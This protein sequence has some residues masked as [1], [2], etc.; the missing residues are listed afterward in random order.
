MKKFSKIYLPLLC[1]A[2]LL[3]AILGLSSCGSD[4]KHDWEIGTTVS[5][6]CNH[7]G[8]VAYTCKKCGDIKT[9]LT[10]ET[11]HSFTNYVDDE[12]ATCE[13]EGTK[14][15]VCDNGCGATDTQSVPK[16]HVYE[17]AWTATADGH[18]HVC[19]VCGGNDGL[20]AHTPDASG[21]ACTVCNYMIHVHNPVKMPTVP[22]T[23]TTAG[24]IE[25]W[26]CGVC[27]KNFSDAECTN[28][29]ANVSIA[30][31][32]HTPTYIEAKAAT[33]TAPGNL[34]S[35][36]CGTC[37]KHYSDEA[38][39][40]PLSD[41]D[42]ILPVINHI[43]NANKWFADKNGHWNECA[44][45]AVDESSRANHVPG[46]AAT[47]YTDQLCTVCNYIITPALNHTHS[48][49]HVPAKDASCTENGNVEYWACACGKYFAD[50]SC[51]VVLLDGDR[52]IAKL[53]H[54][55]QHK[56]A[57][58]P[59]CLEDGYQEHWYCERCEKHFSDK[60]L[61]Y[62]ISYDSIVRRAKHT[63]VKWIQ[64]VAATCTKDG[65]ITYWH[66]ETCNK[67]YSDEALK[68]EITLAD[69]VITATGHNATYVN[70]KA[71]TCTEKGTLGYWTCNNCKKNYTTV[72]CTTIFDIADRT[73]DA[74]GHD[75][76]EMPVSTVPPTCTEGGYSVFKCIRENCG[77]SVRDAETPPTGHNADN[78]VIFD[79]YEGSCQEN[80]YIIYTCKDNCGYERTEYT[81][82]T[83]HDY[84]TATVAPTCT[85]AGYDRHVCADCGYSYKDNETA[86][87]GSHSYKV[88]KTNPEDYTAPTCTAAG[89]QTWRCENGECE[90][91]YTETLSALGHDVHPT[92]ESSSQCSRCEYTA[93]A[94]GHNYKTSNEAYVAP[95]C[96]E[97]GYFVY[98]CSNTGCEKP[99]LNEYPAGDE[100]EPLGHI[101][102]A[103]AEWTKT[104][105]AV[106]GVDC[107][108]YIERTAS[109]KCGRCGEDAVFTE[110]GDTFVEHKETA[111]IT[112]EATCQTPG[113]KTYTCSVCNTSRTEDYVPETPNHTWG[114]GVLQA[115]EVTT[116]YTCV[117]GE[118]KTSVSAKQE[119]SANINSET[120]KNSDDVELKNATFVPSQSVKDNL[121]GN[122]TFGAEA[123]DKSEFN[124]ST[125][126]LDRIGNQPIYDF[127]MKIGG[128]AQTDLGGEMTVRIP[129]TLGE[130]EDPESIMV[131]YIKEGEVTEIKAI[132]VVIDGTG[133]AEFVTTH[134]SYYTVTKME[135]KERCKLWGHA[136]EDVLV[137]ATCLT[138]G[139]TM[140]VCTRCG[141][142]TIDKSE[143][144]LVKAL[145]H[146]FV[147][148]GETHVGVTCTEDGYS[149]YSCDRCH[150]AHYT[151]EEKA[152]GHSFTLSSEQSTPATCTELGENVYVCSCGETKTE[153]TPLAH[154]FR[155]GT[156]QPTC[157]ENGYD[158]AICR[159]CGYEDITNIKLATGHTVEDHAVLA[160]CIDD[161]YT[162]HYCTTCG[163]QF[164]NTN[165]V[166]T[167]GEHV[168]DREEPDCTHDK[169]CVNCGN[170]AEN[171]KATGHKFNTD[172][173]C[174]NENCKERCEHNYVYLKDVAATCT[175]RAHKLEQ[176]TVCFG[177]HEY[178]FT[179]EALAHDMENG[180]C[181]SCGITSGNHYLSMVQTWKNINGF[182][183]KLTDFSLSVEELIEEEAEWYVMV[184][185]AQLN[186]AEL[187]LYVDA[188]GNLAGAATGTISVSYKSLGTQT[189]V[190]AVN[191][192]IENGNVYLQLDTEIGNKGAKDTQY[193]VVSLDFILASMIEE[194]VGFDRKGMEVV[195]DWFDSYVS[196]IISEFGENN[197][198]GINALVGGFVNM[199]FTEEHTED[200][201]VYIFDYNK[202]QTVNNDLAKLTVEEFIDKYFGDASF[203]NLVASIKAILNTK[204][205]EIPALLDS[206]G[207]NS[208][209]LAEAINAFAE[210]TQPE[211]EEKFD[212]MTLVNNPE[213]ATLSIGTL[214]FQGATEEQ[215]TSMISEVSEMLK[216]TSAYSLIAMMMTE[217]GGDPQ[218]TVEMIRGTVE[219]AIDF[220]AEIL[221]VS[222]ETN[223]AGV[224]TD[225]TV[226][227]KD[228]EIEVEG[229]KVSASLTLEFTPNGR[230]NVNFD[231]IITKINQQ[232]NFPNM[233][234]SS[235]IFDWG[236]N[237]F[238]GVPP[239][240]FEYKGKTYTVNQFAPMYFKNKTTNYTNPVVT[241]II[242]RCGDTYLS[243]V[244]YKSTVSE[245]NVTIYMLALEKESVIIV[246]DDVSG[247]ISE[248]SSNENGSFVV[249]YPD[250]TTKTLTI[251]PEEIMYKGMTELVYSAIPASWYKESSFNY[252]L[253]DSLVLLYDA[254]SGEYRLVD[255]MDELHNYVLDREN[256]IIT[257]ECEATN[258]LHYV[259]TKCGDVYA[260]YS[261][262]RHSTETS[263]VLHE[264]AT[265]CEDGVDL[266]SYCT[267]CD[268]VVYV[269]ENWSFGH[270]IR[271]EKTYDESTSTVISTESC[272]CGDTYSQKVYY[273]LDSEIEAVFGDYTTDN[274]NIR[275]AFKLTPTVSGTYEFW[276]ASKNTGFVVYV[277]DANGKMLSNANTG[278]MGGIIGD[279]ENGF[280]GIVISSSN[281]AYELT[282]GST[283]YIT[284]GK[285]HWT[286]SDTPVFKINLRKSE[287]ISLEEY[288]CTC[289]AKMT[290]TDE[291]DRK[292]VSF[293]DCSETCTLSHRVEET[294]LSDENCNIYNS[295]VVYFSVNGGEETAYELYRSY[296]GEHCHDEIGRSYHTAS[297][298]VGEDGKLRRKNTEITVYTCSKCKNEVSKQERIYISDKQT[299][300]TVAREENYYRWSSDV[301]ALVLAQS[302]KTEYELVTFVNGTTEELIVLQSWFNYDAQGNE[303]NGY[304]DR[305]IYNPADPCIKTHIRR[306][307]NGK[308]RT[309]VELNHREEQ[310][311]IPEESTER[312]EIDE[313]GRELTVITEAHE[314]YC[315]VCNASI[316]KTVTIN[317]KTADGS[318]EKYVHEYYEQYAEGEEDYGYVLAG[319]SESETGYV[320]INGERHSYRISETNYHFDMGECTYW[321]KTEFIYNQGDFCHYI[322]L[323]TDMHN[324]EGK[325]ENYTSTS[326]IDW[327][328]YYVLADGSSSCLDGLER[329]YV[330]D[331]C[332]SEPEYNG[333]TNMGYHPTEYGM[334][335]VYELKDYGSVCGGTVIEKTCPCGQRKDV[336]VNTEC[337]MECK[338]EYFNQPDGYGYGWRYTYG[339]A[340]TKPEC[341]FTYTYE[342]G[343]KRGE[344]CKKIGYN[345]YTFGG[346]VIYWEYETSEYFHNDSTTE[347]SPYEI[348]EDGYTVIVSGNRSECLD[349]NMPTQTYEYKEY[350]SGDVMV[351]YSQKYLYYTNGV[352]T[353]ASISEYARFESGDRCQYF[354]TLSRSE[355]YDEYGN[356]TAWQKTEYDRTAGCPLAPNVTYTSDKDYN[357]YTQEHFRYDLDFVEYIE[358]PTCSQFGIEVRCCSW[359]S[360]EATYEAAPHNHNFYY[361][362]ET[363][364]HIC[365]RCGLESSVG[366]NGSI[367]L[368]DLTEKLGGGENIVIGYWNQ[369]G[370][371]FSVLLTLV[372][373]EKIEVIYGY[374]PMDDGNSLIYIN[375][376]EV[377]A[378][379]KAIS[380][381]YS[382][383]EQMLRINLVP[384]TD[385][386]DMEYAITLDPIVFPSA[387]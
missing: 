15:A 372:T 11:G 144:H 181:K 252:V 102:P 45:G 367:I 297:D 251:T 69:T 67:Y 294:E 365:T 284:I 265:S 362:G 121:N 314:T 191:A 70:G 44:C 55:E 90:S 268:K 31:L 197:A 241:S 19:S 235:E 161:G 373:D 37:D 386:T 190:Y 106:E 383:S 184:E 159:E 308:E 288:G 233:G 375:I 303:T 135:A 68:T 118:T 203:E 331:A 34:A 33:C 30:P 103:N 325:Y 66:C 324:P 151:V 332:H 104:K 71:A 107:T 64:G 122:V 83:D 309:T 217:E 133:Y 1:L 95:T 148:N 312:T 154:K 220:V 108:Y 18:F 346:L 256:S 290:V 146:N 100:H 225:I 185:A 75:I 61:K 215:Y 381:D 114:E 139:Y 56:E 378:A 298:F 165:I 272:A 80:G 132:Y 242:A 257:D 93:P 36:Y 270:D 125:E 361:D 174:A 119:T 60:F 164:E 368:E 163:V 319:K 27:N 128:T 356:I 48:G 214:L 261:V 335:V 205:P 234:S 92:C 39:L 208:A 296:T 310:K 136:I 253:T 262:N 230:I 228:L 353:S 21:S 111:K 260:E 206:L 12:N 142:T 351:K 140:H 211:N 227:I 321:Y 6:G 169:L 347:I 247:E 188:D 271:T 147:L 357:S 292:T 334:S 98:T 86:A 123:K 26:H 89:S 273:V 364:K 72:D 221:S 355:Y 280:G 46:E 23:C 254:V 51:T 180:I 244:M 117:C 109:C 216:M 286:E 160:T 20:V 246:V 275:D 237:D 129:Y 101:A 189:S 363:D 376:A 49:A 77:H 145:G 342:H 341:D 250:G 201:F 380:E 207:I 348:Y 76:G 359:C 74:L 300:R 168:W 382:I 245:A 369:K 374:M 91:F 266:V 173:T 328:P 239:L 29:I 59:T 384:D 178:E 5:A 130:N 387:E 377:E 9:E 150:I 186:V 318:Y 175:K 243:N 112:T 131:W 255:Y 336:E 10:P 97:S 385:E 371:K 193:I 306:E 218:E 304:C 78:E 127:T 149:E 219:G 179:G 240:T 198:D 199:F 73:I 99:T 58:N 152:K 195:I 279:K 313:F 172:G 287:D 223:A 326:H 57:K 126:V 301:N 248:I 63:A 40:A 269:E 42:R 134:F 13:T 87:I 182:A 14:T 194:T 293:T 137:P 35:Y 105:K 264:G 315:S 176:C 170:R 278:G 54:V 7:K 4:C 337:D 38:C 276:S 338:E 24:S 157:T 153:Q 53:G 22:S 138:D 330:C 81:G 43:Y 47:E 115:D 204:I 267:K 167:K 79:Q 281:K 124:L 2:V 344:G 236:T 360:F 340:V 52:I 85:E 120:I 177:T 358:E 200:G 224:I 345:V 291:F 285:S 232:I 238:E 162:E 339:C 50:A 183:L 116:V 210:M 96:T 274:M 41:A 343:Y 187:M 88:D 322:T 289:G 316:S 327:H 299:G 354:Q 329:Y 8:A 94:T 192:V 62:E 366:H 259:C 222:Y 17:S 283:Y 65:N 28:E 32:G 282:A 3:V 231:G 110:T 226:A 212:I 307:A 352:P 84:I 82:K 370:I 249:T 317:Y 302:S 229:E 143:G 196:P 156:K 155:T 320:T 209:K 379:V 258:Y 350:Y 311:L 305:Y 323:R 141:E 16:R 25:H 349:C 263:F 158:Y 213:Y 171:G 333:Y 277:Y 113:E 295:T 202:L 166:K